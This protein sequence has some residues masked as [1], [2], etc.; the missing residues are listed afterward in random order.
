[1]NRMKALV[2]LAPITLACTTL[3]SACS[4][5]PQTKNGG[6]SAT[7]SSYTSVGSYIPRKKSNGPGALNA[8]TADMQALE[9]SRNNGN[10]VMNLPVK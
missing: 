9:N 4:S 10:G 5:E 2:L 8:G 3:L 1:M 6:G 7:E